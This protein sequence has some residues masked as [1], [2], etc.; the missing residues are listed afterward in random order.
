MF[1]RLRRDNAFLSKSKLLAALSASFSSYDVLPLS[2]SEVIEKY[3]HQ[4]AKCETFRDFSVKICPNLEILENHMLR[5]RKGKWSF[6][7]SHLVTEPEDKQALLE[8]IDILRE[9]WKTIAIERQHA[10]KD[11]EFVKAQVSGIDVHDLSSEESQKALQDHVMTLRWE[12]KVDEAREIRDAWRRMIE[13]GPKEDSFLLDR[14]CCLYGIIKNNAFCNAFTNTIERDPGSS[15]IV[16]NKKDLYGE[17]AR[18]LIS[19]VPVM[20]VFYAFL[21]FQPRSNMNE[22]AGYGHAIGKYLVM[23]LFQ[24][25]EAERLPD[26]PES[27]PPNVR[28]A[29]LGSTTDEKEKVIFDSTAEGLFYSNLNGQE[30]WPNSNTPKY[31]HFRRINQRDPDSH[32]E[33]K[34]FAYPVANPKDIYIATLILIASQNPH[35]RR[36][37]LPERKEK[38]GIAR[39]LSFVL[40]VPV[41]NVRLRVLFLP[42]EHLD[43]VSVDRLVEVLGRQVSV[44]EFRY[45]HGQYAKELDSGEV[46]YAEQRKKLPQ[47]EWREL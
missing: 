31:L 42:P 12:G 39:R 10:K 40:G 34:R 16:L 18:L 21:G 47:E 4:E 9:K 30:Q 25:Y 36:V 6:R 5:W 45:F 17:T 41:D 22:G 37:Q 3:Y 15:Q 13:N 44:E 20:D 2:H 27:L 8:Q 29:S 19:N 28:R 7:V 26:A 11:R 23:N 33:N 32:E 46:D 1:H 38:D 24:K 35:E 43:G 14:L